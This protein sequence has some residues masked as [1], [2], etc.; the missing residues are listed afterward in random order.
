[1]QF[2]LRFQIR[3]PLLLSGTWALENAIDVIKVRVPYPFNSNIKVAADMQ[4]RDLIVQDLFDQCASRFEILE[5]GT[6]RPLVQV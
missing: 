5:N 2:I 6:Y 4:R 3:I 1:M